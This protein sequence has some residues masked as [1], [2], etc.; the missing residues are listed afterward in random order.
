MLW[1][2]LCWR[3]TLKK[4][5]PE[6]CTRNL[7]GK[8]L[9]QVRHSFLHLNNSPA[10][11]VARFVSRADSFCAGIEICIL[12]RARNL[13]QKKLI[14]DWPTHVQVSY[15]RRLAQV[16]WYKF[17]FS[18]CHWHQSWEINSAR[19]IG[20]LCVLSSGRSIVL[21]SLADC[22]YQE[23][24]VIQQR[25]WRLR[26]RQSRIRQR[27]RRSRW[28]RKRE[29]RWGR[30]RVQSLRWRPMQRHCGKSVAG[31]W[32]LQCADLSIHDITVC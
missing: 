11:H 1:N 25:S 24:T 12:L 6:T 7:H 9:T 31:Q 3:H 21:E 20:W 2:K 26:R 22:V 4:L 16:S 15:T 5:A 14:T 27:W 32:L 19:V 13:Y 8:I 30:W 18:L 10:N 29:R 28:R 17:K 23:A